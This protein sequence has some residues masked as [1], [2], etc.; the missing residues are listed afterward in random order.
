[1]TGGRARGDG[2]EAAFRAF[3]RSLDPRDQRTLGDALLRRVDGGQP[4]D[5]AMEE[6]LVECGVRRAEARKQVRVA[7]ARPLEDGGW[8]SA[9]N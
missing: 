6:W 1:V 3:Y 7:L 8:R 5:E 9:L 2:K 4:L